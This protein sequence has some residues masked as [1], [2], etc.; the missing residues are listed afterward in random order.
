[1]TFQFKKNIFFL[2]FY[3]NRIVG[4]TVFTLVPSIRFV[5]MTIC[6]TFSCQTINQKSLTVFSF[7][8]FKLN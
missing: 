2:L 3:L 5:N 7:G 1:M 6:A 4:L 8:P